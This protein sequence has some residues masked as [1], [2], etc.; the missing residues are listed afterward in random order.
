MAL[1]LVVEDDD[2]VREIVTAHL[3]RGG[4]QVMDAGSG[5]AALA[6]VERS[7]PDVAVVDL[8]LPDMDGFALVDR[9]QARADCAELPIVFLTGRVEPDQVAAGSRRAARYLVKPFLG[10]ALR[11]AVD[12]SLREHEFAR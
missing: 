6:C 4:H 10:S 5:G 9:L 7:A 1:V 8:G 12:E 2:V 3:H 11:D